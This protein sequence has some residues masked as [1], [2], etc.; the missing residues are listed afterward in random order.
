ML[1]LHSMIEYS[2]CSFLV[3]LSQALQST[4]PWF[5]CDLISQDIKLNESHISSFPDTA[6]MI[7]SKKKNTFPCI[8]EILYLWDVCCHEDGVGPHEHAWWWDMLWKRAEMSYIWITSCFLCL[9][10]SQFRGYSAEISSWIRR[11]VLVWAYASLICVVRFTS[12]CRKL[13]E[14]IGW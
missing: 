13:H 10:G 3:R 9:N 12:M 11:K 4:I 2:C 5:C 14:Y 7:I 1:S 8:C 6:Q